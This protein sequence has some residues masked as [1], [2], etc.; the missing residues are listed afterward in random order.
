MTL[1]SIKPQL[2]RLHRW[3][4][5]VFALPLAFVII[6]G[7]ILSFEPIAQDLATKPGTLSAVRLVSLLEEHDKDGKTRAIT[8]RAYE[9]RLTL[10]GVGPDGSLDLAISSGTV[11]D[12]DDR[13]MLSDIFR[14]ARGLHE[15][16]LFDQEWVVTASTFAMLGLIALGVL[17]GWP[18]IRNTMS[19]WHQAVAWFGLP[20]VVLSP[21]T[22]LAIAY[23]VTFSTPQLQDRAALPPIKQAV[24]MLGEKTDLS[25]LIWLRNRGGRMLARVNEGGVFKVYQVSIRGV[26]PA[27]SN[28]PRAL[29]EGNFAGL[30]SG[31]M[32]LV[33]SLG[34]LILMGTG[35]TIWFRRTF[36]K[37]NRMRPP[38]AAPAE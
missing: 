36:R 25:G 21:L 11:M 33:T 27:S 18:R 14:A 17:M 15:H 5:L 29:H 24:Q 2:L 22:G 32:V 38:V 6:T 10:Q 3:T 1:L 12:D 34:M 35:L 7:L 37:R 30:W 4:T 9:D 20:L 19:G 13:T 16:F 31:L 28:W 8:M 23:G 26:M